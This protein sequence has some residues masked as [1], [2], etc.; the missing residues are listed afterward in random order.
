MMF[1]CF[2]CNQFEVHVILYTRSGGQEAVHL[3]QSA[4]GTGVTSWEPASSTGSAG[5]MVRHP[6]MHSVI[7]HLGEGTIA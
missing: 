4:T 1:C 2:E 6:G 7:C 5:N 3:G